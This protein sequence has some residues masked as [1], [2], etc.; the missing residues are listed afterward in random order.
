AV[1]VVGRSREGGRVP[2]LPAEVEPAQE[3]ERLP[4]RHTLRARKRPRE[5]EACS[6][7]E[8][9]LRPTARAARGRKKEDTVHAGSP[10]GVHGSRGPSLRPLLLP[11][12][13]RPRTRAEARRCR[14]SSTGARP[15]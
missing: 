6:S 14:A 11:A 2:E 8:Q 13:L 15:P 12:R 10:G 4:E 3:R 1:D 9:D 5:I 7:P